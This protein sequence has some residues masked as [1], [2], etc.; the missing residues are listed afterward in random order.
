MVE[1]H[2]HALSEGGYRLP[3][4]VSQYE[5][6]EEENIAAQPPAQ[7]PLMTWT[8]AIYIRVLV[9]SL[10]LSIAFISMVVS[11]SVTTG[12]AHPINISAVILG[13]S[14]IKF[15]IKLSKTMGLTMRPFSREE[16]VVIQTI[17]VSATAMAFNG[18]FGNYLLGMSSRI[19]KQLPT[20]KIEEETVDP[21]LGVM[22]LFLIV[23]NLFGFFLLVLLFRIMIVDFNLQ[24][25][26]GTAAGHLI[27]NLHMPTADRQTNHC[28]WS[29]T[30]GVGCG[31][32]LPFFGQEAYENQFYLEL[33]AAYIGIGMMC[34]HITNISQLVGGILAAVILCPFLETK[35][36]HWYPSE[37]EPSSIY[38]L[39]GYKVLIAIATIL[40]D[41]LYHLCKMVGC[42]CFGVYDRFCKRNRG[43]LSN[44]D[45]CRQEVFKINFFG[46]T[47]CLTGLVYSGF[48]LLV[49]AV[50]PYFKWYQVAAILFVIAP[51][52]AFCNAYVRGQ[53]DWSLAPTFGRVA[54]IA[55][56]AWTTA[57]HA[58]GGGVLA[59]LTACGIVTNVVFTGS[60]L[61]QEYKIA[62]MTSVSP[63]KILASQ[64]VGI[65]MGSVL[66][67]SIYWIFMKG[68]KDIGIPES[69]HPAPYA[70]IYRSMSILGT[71]GFSHLP[72]YC[73]VFSFGFFLGAI[74][75]NLL[76]DILERYNKKCAK[77]FPG[78]MPLAIGILTRAIAVAP[79][80]IT[81]NF[82][83]DMCFGSLVMF[84]WQK[85]DKPKAGTFGLVVA[86]GLICGEGLWAITTSILALSGIKAPVCMKVLSREEMKKLGTV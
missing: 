81:S 49:G 3:S 22:I 71:Q 74:V 8:R 2:R 79:D 14:S 85:I 45:A 84:I 29:L 54:I 59:G 15:C 73:H 5:M 57:S 36:G 9:V 7:P 34:P 11:I 18:G 72:E 56:S 41:G 27:N 6:L 28:K 46:M 37:L 80:S 4:L 40:G 62:Y 66:S 77:F 10:F 21:G 75:L 53:S 51:T 23:F 13:F 63:D 67:P 65:I 16:N 38:G 26:S 83:L 50:I 55:F 31:L 69:T 64:F 1:H 78:P 47:R 35:K 48:A 20:A 44:Q 39:E 25:P 82:V 60:D 70:L 58:D 33:S 32:V 86:S 24:Y 52:L 61:V 30:R 19:A 68:F 17:I 42:T 76:K 43:P 12:I